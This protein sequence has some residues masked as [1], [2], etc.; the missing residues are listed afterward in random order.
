MN[1]LVRIKGHYFFRTRIPK[2]LY[3]LLHRKEIKKSLHT[4]S[5]GNAKVI[6]KAY[7]YRL[8]RIYTIAR[9]GMMTDAEVRQLMHKFVSDTLRDFEEG[10]SINP[11]THDGEKMQKAYLL[12]AD[13]DRESLVRNDIAGVRE[14]LDG[15]IKDRGLEISRDSMEYHRLGREMLKARQVF[16]KVMAEREIGNYDNDY[17]RITQN[18]TRPAD[19]QPNEQSQ[20][21]R[22]IGISLSEAFNRYIQQQADGNAWKGNPK[23]GEGQAQTIKR[24][25]LSILGDKDVGLYTRQNALDCRSTLLALPTYAFDRKGLKELSISEKIKKA[26]A[27]DLKTLSTKTVN[28]YTTI[29]HAVVET[30]KH[31]GLPMNHFINLRVE[32]ELLPEDQWQAYTEDDIKALLSSPV[33]TT[34]RSKV[35]QETPHQFWIPLLALFTGARMNE[36]CS[37]WTANIVE[38][39][40]IS[41]IEIAR[42][43]QKKRVKTKAG[44]RIVPIHPMLREIGFLEYVKAK[45]AEGEQRLWPLLTWTDY[46]AY[47]GGFGQWY[48]DY[49]RAFITREERKTFKSFRHTVQQNLG[50]NQVSDPVIDRLIG[51][52]GPALARRYKRYDYT[53]ATL[54]EQGIRKLEYKGVDFSGLKA[55]V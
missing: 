42:E 1:Y 16:W 9:G 52:A 51:H 34:D 18:L 4:Q 36:L 7:S 33:Y 19:A 48:S 39:E 21:R 29:L 54:F 10:R 43:A 24:I 5:F 50:E 49:N 26:E 28:E 17:D 45:G 22:T 25:F 53:T 27:L 46:Q 20:G 23:K 47:A 38:L 41:C 44:K 37:L 12:M 6:A 8:E 14:W 30:C 3:P 31:D 35:C 55:P 40:G 11:T 2:D 15:L 32:H 13:E